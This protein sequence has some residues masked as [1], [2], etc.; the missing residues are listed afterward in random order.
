MSKNKKVRNAE[1]TIVDGIKFRS[2]LEAYCYNELVSN[3]FEPEYENKKFVIFKGFKLRD[4]FHVYMPRS[5]KHC[6]AKD[7]MHEYERAVLPITYTPDFYLHVNDKNVFIEVKG[8]AND[9]YP[10]KRKMYFYAMNSGNDEAY[11]FEPHNK[12]Q[13]AQLIEI[14]HKIS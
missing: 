10:L 8:N 9:Q 12:A 3:G 14:L 11:F 4:N 5:K 2:K 7:L 1:E 13:I 6:R